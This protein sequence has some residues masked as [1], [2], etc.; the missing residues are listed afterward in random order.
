MADRHD[1][2]RNADPWRRLA[3]LA[4]RLTVADSPPS[5]SPRAALL[6]F[7]RHRRF[8]AAEL[9]RIRAVVEADDDFRLRLLAALKPDHLNGEIIH[10]LTDP[11]AVAPSPRRHRV[12]ESERVR[13]ELQRLTAE[14]DHLRR[15]VAQ[16]DETVRQL[17]DRVDRRELRLADVEEDLRRVLAER[18]AARGELTRQQVAWEETRSQLTVRVRELTTVIDELMRQ[19]V[20]LDERL[21]DLASDLA[22]QQ[23]ERRMSR[24]PPPQARQPL[25]IP[26]GLLADSVEAARFLLDRTDVVVIVD[27]YNAVLDPWTEGPLSQRRHVLL[28]AL[29]A[30]I[31]HRGPRVLVVF[32]GAADVGGGGDRRLSRVVFSDPDVIADDVVC[33]EIERLPTTTP[34][35]V[36][37][38]DQGLVR[39]VR[40]QGANAVSVAHL[41]GVLRR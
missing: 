3:E 15:V 8:T 30:F 32:D 5:S 24:P 18:D 6:R 36:V 39:R 31:A 37:T 33:L 12:A 1:D 13:V 23:R 14:R 28:S 40:R 20:D 22:G 7:A 19:R 29:D 34:V 41:W 4:V 26:G 21:A 10:W 38:D 35:V 25:G 16:R 11:T 17:Q 9:D 27:G 2:Q